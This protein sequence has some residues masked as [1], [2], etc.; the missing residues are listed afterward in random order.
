MVERIEYWKGFTGGFIAGIVAGAWI[1]LSQRSSQNIIDAER[2]S[3]GESYNNPSL[4]RDEEVSR[5]SSLAQ[6]AVE[7]RLAARSAQLPS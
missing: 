2:F 5:L 4:S 1:Y 7:K 3:H 6:E